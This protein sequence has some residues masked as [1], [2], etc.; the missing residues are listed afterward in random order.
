M[1]FDSVNQHLVH[2][3]E[4]K[5]NGIL[6]VIFVYLSILYISFND[7]QCSCSNVTSGNVSMVGAGKTS[8]QKYLFLLYG[9]ETNIMVKKLSMGTGFWEL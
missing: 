7:H 1:N 9:I 8:Y 6:T 2:Q 4:A 5:W 3:P